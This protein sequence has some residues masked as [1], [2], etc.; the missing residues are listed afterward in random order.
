MEFEYEEEEEL[1][2]E[3]LPIIAMINRIFAALNN[4]KTKPWQQDFLM[5]PKQ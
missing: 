4:L 1:L 3:E 2:P 5:S